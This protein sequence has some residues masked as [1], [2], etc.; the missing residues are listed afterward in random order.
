MILVFHIDRQNAKADV[1]RKMSD[2]A[3]EQ[4][5]IYEEFPDMVAS[6]IN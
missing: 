4:N 3:I 2:T 5:K 6:Y 1:L